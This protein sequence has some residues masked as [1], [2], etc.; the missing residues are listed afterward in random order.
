MKTNDHLP[1]AP[2]APH[3]ERYNESFYRPCGMS[4]I[5]LP[6]L[7]LGLWHNFGDSDNLHEGRNMLRRAFDLGVTHFDLANNYGPP[8]GSAEQNFG[9]IF[10]QDFEAYRHEL[11]IATK[12]GYDM[13][14]GPFGRGGSKKYLI[15]SLD[16][17]L[18]RMKSDYVDL[19]YHH[20]PD[21]STPVEET[22]DALALMHQQ[23]K[24]LY[25]GI[26]NYYT[27]EIAKPMVKALKDRCVPLFINQLRYNPLDRKAEVLFPVCEEEGFGVIAFSPLAQGILSGKYNKG[28]PENSRA[29]NSASYLANGPEKSFVEKAIQLEKLAKEAGLTLIELTFL[30]ILRNKTVASVLA[31]ASN[32]K[33]I[34]E[35]VKAFEKPSLDD[36]IVRKMDQ[37]V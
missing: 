33:Q 14:P 4:G 22:A 3:P 9:T 25:I 29:A 21:P 37:I 7:T 20:T 15:N 23:G 6:K 5:Q 26:S 16:L 36:E 18:K 8:Y 32:V 35:N 30:W 1:I 31:G 27:P 10:N 19:F 34:E 2:Y 12:A 24:A 17:S 11:F 13:W 28:I